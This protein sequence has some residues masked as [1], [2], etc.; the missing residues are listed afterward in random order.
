MTLLDHSNSL[1][2][3][4]PILKGQKR[5]LKGVGADSEHVYIYAYMQNVRRALSNVFVP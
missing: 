1:L 2:N 3:L 5:N 4:L